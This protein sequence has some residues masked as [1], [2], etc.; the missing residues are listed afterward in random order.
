VKPLASGVMAELVLARTAPAERPIVLKCVRPGFAVDDTFLDAFEGEGKRAAE[1]RHPNV[2]QV[3]E[4][5]LE[6]GMHFVA[7]EYIHGDDV[8]KLLARLHERRAKLPVQHILSIGTS[9]AQALQHAHDKGT[10]HLGIKPSNVIIAADGTV[11]VA[12]FGIAR[13]AL[14]ESRTDLVAG[15]AGYLSPEQ[16]L[17]QEVDHRSDVFGLG[18]LLYELSVGRRLFKGDNDLVTMA[19]I[20]AG[21]IPAPTKHR[22]DLPKDLEAIVM[23]ALARAPGDRYQ[24]AHEMLAALEKF[25]S[26]AGIRGSATTLSGYTKRLFG[27]RPEPSID[28]A[29][30]EAIPTAD[31]DASPRGLATPPPEAAHGDLP[32]SVAAD[33]ASPIMRVRS[34]VSRDPTDRVKVR[35][36]TAPIA[37]ANSGRVAKAPPPL[38]KTP[39]PRVKPKTVQIPTG[40]EKKKDH[41]TEKNVVVPETI[42][43]FS[44]DSVVTDAALVAVSGDIVAHTNTDRDMPR[45][46]M[47]VTALP[48][49]TTLPRVDNTAAVTPLPKSLTRAGNMARARNTKLIAFGVFGAI[50]VAAIVIVI[51]FSTDD[52][53]IAASAKPHV[54]I[55]AKTE[56]APQLPKAEDLRPDETKPEEY[57]TSGGPRTPRNSHVTA[58]DQ[59]TK[60]EPKPTEDVDP[61][62]AAEMKKAEAELAKAEA[63]RLAAEKAQEKKDED[64]RERE[65]A[66]R[67]ALEKAEAKKAAD[68]ARKAE[69]A[70][71]KAKADEAKKAALA[72]SEA[73]KAAAIAAKKTDDKVVAKKTEPKK[74]TKT[75]PKK[76]TT[77]TKGKWDSSALFPP[78]K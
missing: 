1:L 20:V 45:I 67:I 50:A 28:G 19:A 38:P 71:K 63:K 70:E 21:E 73:K 31:F 54:P 44:D 18:I 13:A 47:V 46:P 66:R 64:E 43:Q 9:V 29:T 36:P 3:R 37:N 30:A 58:D 75:E 6:G 27:M 40:G 60:E 17:G 78:T 25:A 39:V 51:G 62:V 55:A 32:A 26:K 24:T 52:P 41:T 7:M 15:V 59:D 5:G 42:P 23:K 53:T 57:R 69:L 11:K 8:R 16:C 10:L 33:E 65:E 76:P 14:V 61:K 68:E 2:V 35:I 34:A 12:D 74:T 4:V 48:S 56:E 72:E 49:T 22:G 77:P